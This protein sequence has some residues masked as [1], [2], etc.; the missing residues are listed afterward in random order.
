MERNNLSKLNDAFGF[1]IQRNRW[2]ESRKKNIIFKITT[3]IP[4]FAL[5]LEINRCRKSENKKLPRSVQVR[6][7]LTASIVGIPVV[8]LVDI[9][10]TLISQPLGYYRDWKQIQSNNI[11]RKLEETWIPELDDIIESKEPKRSKPKE[12]L[13]E[14]ASA[15]ELEISPEPSTQETEELEET[16]ETDETEGLEET[17]ETKETDETTTQELG[18]IDSSES[19]T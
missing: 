14:E 9:L 3:L 2:A 18:N 16:D 1:P 4:L 12:P 11:S 17:N 8:L 7:G 15:G 6:L 19:S 5:G 13:E 10:T